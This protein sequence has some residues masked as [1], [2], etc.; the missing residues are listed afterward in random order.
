MNDEITLYNK[1]YNLIGF[2]LIFKDTS[3]SINKQLKDY[4]MEK[5]TRYI[6]DIIPEYPIFY[7]KKYEDFTLYV[8]SNYSNYLKDKLITDKVNKSVYTCTLFY[9]LYLNNQ[10]LAYEFFEEYIMKFSDIKNENINLHQILVNI[11]PDIILCKNEYKTCGTEE[12]FNYLDRKYKL[13]LFF[14]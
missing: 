12:N 4:V 9:E 5:Y 3:N 1:L 8:D 11:I 7:N 13:D 6:S 2:S 10:I 14:Q